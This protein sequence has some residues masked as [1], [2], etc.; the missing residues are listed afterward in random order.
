MVSF[1]NFL[2]FFKCVEFPFLQGRALWFASQFTDILPTHI[3]QEYFQGC[4]QSL[5]DSQSNPIV[6]IF[7]LKA[8][9]NFCMI[10]ENDYLVQYQLVLIQR[11]VQFV[12]L[13][14]EEVLILLLE[15]LNF[16]VRINEQVSAQ[17]ESILGPLLVQVWSRLANGILDCFIF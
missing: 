12:P 2:N 5:Q 4:I 15:T 9:R 14:S 7:A 17:Q 13:A 6:T 10:L 1:L 3:M 8:I 16:V 11:I